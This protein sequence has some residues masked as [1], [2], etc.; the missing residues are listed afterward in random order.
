LA[1]AVQGNLPRIC[2]P[3][4]ITRLASVRGGKAPLL[5]RRPS[6]RTT[7]TPA[8]AAA[9]C[10]MPPSPRRQRSSSDSGCSLTSCAP[11]SAPCPFSNSFATS[12]VPR[13]AHRFPSRRTPASRRAPSAIPGRSAPEAGALS[14]VAHPPR[15]RHHDRD[16]PVQSCAI[17]PD[18][19]ARPVRRRRALLPA[20]RHRQAHHITRRDLPAQGHIKALLQGLPGM[21][22]QQPHHSDALQHAA[23][24]LHP[25]LRAATILMKILNP[26]E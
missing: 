26:G 8:R 15:A 11:R 18:S 2:R 7:R 17:V 22:A 24:L 6:D 10:T 4:L 25:Q 9:H 12:C 13:V 5:P 14:C 3:S 19:D 21:P 16:A 20:L 23:Q 1:P